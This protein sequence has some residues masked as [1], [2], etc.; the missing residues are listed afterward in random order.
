MNDDLLQN[1]LD[2]V[3]LIQ[4]LNDL[5]Q[6]S[7][8]SSSLSHD[9]SIFQQFNQI[10][11]KTTPYQFDFII[12]NER[13]IKIFGIPLYSQKSLLPIIDPK[14]FQSINKT[15]LNI[16]LSNIDNYP[17]P[18]YNQWKW[19]WDQWY[20]FMYKDVDPHGWMYSTALFQSDRRWRGKYYFGNSVRRRIWIRMRQRINKEEI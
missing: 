5:I 9:L 15:N 16:P 17:L 18:D 10:I 14:Q 7:I 19:N 4:K 1:E 12:E 2:S 6:K 11:S 20:L 8:T 13:G 3:K